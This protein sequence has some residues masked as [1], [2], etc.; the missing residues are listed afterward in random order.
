MG[1]TAGG[2]KDDTKVSRKVKKK[3]WAYNRQWRIKE[4]PQE[5][6]IQKKK[7]KGTLNLP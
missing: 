1:Q 7:A 3:K 4:Y 2:G 5:Q 6:A